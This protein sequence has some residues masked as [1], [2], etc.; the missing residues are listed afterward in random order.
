MKVANGH[1]SK[2]GPYGRKKQKQKTPEIFGFFF[3][4]IKNRPKV[5]VPQKTRARF[6]F[7]LSFGPF[8]MGSKKNPKISGFFCFCFLLP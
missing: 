4:P 6:S 1:L 8:L 5:H 2:A 3:D 7:F